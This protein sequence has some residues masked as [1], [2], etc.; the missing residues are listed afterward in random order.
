MEEKYR[1]QEKKN[2][3]EPNLLDLPKYFHL[4]GLNTFTKI[5]SYLLCKLTRKMS[6]GIS[7]FNEHNK[8]HLAESILQLHRTST[9]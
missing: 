2:P 7:K 4:T 8:L 1:I 9:S 6:V 5:S 3:I